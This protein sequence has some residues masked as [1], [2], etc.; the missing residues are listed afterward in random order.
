M[1]T[2]AE[3]SRRPADAAAD[4]DFQPWFARIASR[5]LNGCDFLVAGRRYRLAEVEMYYFGPGH[6]DPF[7]HRDPVQLED[8]R[9]YFHRTRG[10]YRGGSFKGL[11]LALGDGTSYFGVLIR[12]AVEPGGA[13][14]DGPCVTVDHLLAKTKAASVAVLD[15]LINARSIWDGSSP[16]AIVEAERPRSAP[17]YATSRVGLSLKKARGRPE[18]PRF[19]GRPYRF[20]TEPANISKG[21][22]HLVAALH[23]AGQ[24]P[25]AIREVIG[26]PRKTIDRYV[27]D[28]EAGTRAEDFDAYAGKDLSTAELCQL[29][30]TWHAKFGAK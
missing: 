23:R 10:E 8:G 26:M 30:G 2:L 16:L 3:L 18:M 19:V 7:S 1:P 21:K 11:D 28:F 9:W 17:V 5:L 6:Q 25:E 4:A 15:A 27:A 29:L 20:L 24:T 12:T 13:V 14:L 22:V